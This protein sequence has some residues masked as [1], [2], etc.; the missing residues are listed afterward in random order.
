MLNRKRGLKESRL[1]LCW[2]ISLVILV[3]TGLSSRLIAQDCESALENA[4]ESLIE[5]DYSRII[6]L[7]TDC[8]PDRLLEPSQ[9]IMA[10]RLLSLAYFVTDQEDSSRGSMNRL[11][12]LEPDFD[13]QPPQYSQQFIELL[14][15][16]RTSRMV[17][18]KKRGLLRSK[19][20]WIGG[21]AVTATTVYLIAGGKK[22]SPA[23][24]LPDPPS[25]PGNQ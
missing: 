9:K 25:F 1:F 8:P 4:L 22:E 3:S 23:T 6:A 16:V 24:R 13:P 21:A 15:E 12:D 5:Q 10:Y 19:W 17:A 20:F 2:T 18:D 11:L 7:L 14:E